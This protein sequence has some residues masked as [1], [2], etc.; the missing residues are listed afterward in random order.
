MAWVKI[1]FQ[2]DGRKQAVRKA[3]WKVWRGQV[4]DGLRNE[5][6]PSL[7]SAPFS[8]WINSLGKR[9]M[10]AHGSKI[11]TVFPCLFSICLSLPGPFYYQV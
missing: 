11:V 3:H 10:V 1:M 9:V 2:F 7:T 4:S 5:I 6:N 8:V